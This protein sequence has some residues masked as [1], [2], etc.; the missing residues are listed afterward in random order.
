MSTWIVAVH[1]VIEADDENPRAAIAGAL[2]RQF[3]SLL[4]PPAPAG[5]VLDWAVAGDD[6]AASMAPAALPAGYTPGTAPFPVWPGTQAGAA[7]S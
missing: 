3:G 2:D 4:R 5:T 1:L 6:L 7:M